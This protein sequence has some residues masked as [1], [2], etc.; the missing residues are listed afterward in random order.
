MGNNQG[1]GGSAGGG[2]DASDSLSAPPVY[3]GQVSERTR[4]KSFRFPGGKEGGAGNGNEGGDSPR[5]GVSTAASQAGGNGAGETEFAR[6]VQRPSRYDDVA[7]FKV[8][9]AFDE[10]R[11]TEKV[12]RFLREG[13]DPNFVP[14]AVGV[15]DWTLLHWAAF[16]RATSTIK[17]LVGKG[18]NIN[19]KNAEGDVPAR[20]AKNQGASA[21][22]LRLLEAGR[23]LGGR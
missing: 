17:L 6:R 5:S 15:Y 10:V 4:G 8:R 1:G 9:L 12:E 13:G 21:E 16:Y 20:I 18:A 22:I 14:F 7:L 2:R 19:L 3:G 11:D 23:L